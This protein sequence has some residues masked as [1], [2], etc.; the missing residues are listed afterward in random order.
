[1]LGAHPRVSGQRPAPSVRVGGEAWQALGQ[2]SGAT[3]ATRASVAARRAAG[4]EDKRGAGRR[5]LATD[6]L[7]VQDDDA[8]VEQFADVDGEPG[9]GASAAEMHQAGAEPHGVVPGDDAAVA[10]AENLREIPG[11]SAPDGL[12]VGGRFAEAPIEVGDELG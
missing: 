12:A 10:T 8:A 1:M 11:R 3:D 7:V 4:L 2:R 6:N 9:V 5:R